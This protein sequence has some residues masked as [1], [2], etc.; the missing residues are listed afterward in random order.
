M[1][2][3]LPDQPGAEVRVS[4][5]FGPRRGTPGPDMIVLHYTGMATG[6]GAE[7]WLC[8][9]ASEVSSHYLVHEGGRIVQMVRESDRAWHAGKSSWF[10]RTDINSCSV[11]IEIVN[12]GHL[13]GYKVF[14][15]RQ[16][17]AV[18]GLC[19][20]IIG[21]HSIPPQR[22][23]AHSDVAPGRK[24]DPGEK[25]P[26]KAL[27]AGGVGHLVPAAPIRQGTALKAGDTGADVEAL[28]SML[29]LYG[30]AVEIS[31]V[32][33]RQTEIVVAAFQRHFRRRLVDGVADGSTTRTLQRL[34]ASAK[35]AS[36]K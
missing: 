4:P 17:D 20:G 35:A 14:P 22:V 29:A 19:A 30:Y 28:Q 5:N 8:D 16:I 33:D 11:G 25:F 7:A 27:F 13:L 2:G 12:P 24:V 21:R 6:A 34:L 9:P 23:L 32:F 10:G 3:F 36:T 1:S 18:I 26:W 31:G 15:K